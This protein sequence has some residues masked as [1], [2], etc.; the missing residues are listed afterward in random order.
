MSK[1]LK[2]G[3]SI[4]VAAA[5]LIAAIPAAVFAADDDA[6]LID[7]FYNF[8]DESQ[9]ADWKAAYRSWNGETFTEGSNKW[10]ARE[11][12]TD[13][14]SKTSYTL[15]TGVKNNGEY[16]YYIYNGLLKNAVNSIN[17]IS[18]KIAINDQGAGSRA[19]KLYYDYG[20]DKG[21]QF[22]GERDTNIY[23]LKDSAVNG[24]KACAFKEGNPENQWLTFEIAYDATGVDFTF[25]NELNEV[26][27]FRINEGEGFNPTKFAIM[28]TNRYTYLDDVTFDYNETPATAAENF[29]TTYAA[30]LAKTADTLVISDKSDLE[31][32]VAAYAELDSAV[33]AILGEQKT[34]LDTLTAKMAELEMYNT[35]LTDKFYDFEDESQMADW[36]AAYRSWNGETFTEGSNKWAARESYTD[37]RSKTSYTLRTGVKNNGEYG[38]YIYNGLLK[39]AVNSINK[40]SGKIAINDQG[41]G[42]R[43]IKLYYDYGN[44]KGVQFCGER[45]TNIYYLKDSAVNGNKACA[46]KEGNPENQ[47]LTFE[48]AYDATGVDFTFRNELNEVITFRI[49]EGEGF[50]PTKF[51]IMSTNRYTYLDDVT[52]DYNETPATA[53]ENFKTTYAAILA[54]NVDNVTLEDKAEIINANAAYNALSAEAKALLTDEY[55]TLSALTAKVNELDEIANAPYTL[56]ME[57]GAYLRTVAPTGIRFGV[58]VTKKN[59]ADVTVIEYGVLF[60]PTDKLDG[61][62]LTYDMIKTANANGAKA[63]AAKKSGNSLTVPAKFYGL[64]ANVVPQP[65]ANDNDLNIGNLRFAGRAF[66]TRAYVRY[67]DA[68]NNTKI[69][70]SEASDSRSVYGTAI[71]AAAAYNLGAEFAGYFDEAGSSV[72]V[73]SD[74]TAEQLKEYGMSAIKKLADA[75]VIFQK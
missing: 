24:N 19:I 7:K 62:S 42:S 58:N 41:A 63:L 31:T 73:N 71:R 16:G 65:G 33:Q 26:I 75:N 60:M 27:T 43:A 5:L 35:E 4:L 70:Y 15:R 34:L 25:R 54:K 56:T 10:A 28:S 23:Y 18:G 47:W 21:V 9:M 32:A 3:L 39:N 67:I 64:L 6:E 66:T 52:F 45:D 55:A 69:V 11:S 8:E 74:I 57:N 44:D 20:N 30:I 14:R 59:T 51:A 36:K 72:D 2:K 17:K 61:D 1:S 49:N 37:L 13:L 22:C 68:N 38:Y 50:N 53:A 29:K 12:Y 40:I 48:I 46:F